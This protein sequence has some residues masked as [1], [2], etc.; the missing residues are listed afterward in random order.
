MCPD[1]PAGSSPPETG[2]E[3]SGE[4]EYVAAAAAEH[5]VDS[6][7]LA[8]GRF[9]VPT[10]AGTV[11]GLRYG[12][13]GQ[14][15]PLRT[16]LLHGG[17]Q[18]A[19]TW[20]VLAAALEQPALALDLPGHGRSHAR[21]DH[22]YSPRLLADAVVEAVMRACPDADTLVG[23]SLGGMAA[24]AAAPQVPRL[25]HL[26]LVDVSP[27]SVV[28]A[29]SAVRDVAALPPAPF[30]QLVADVAALTGRPVTDALLHGVWHNTRPV[31]EGRTWL[32]DR[33]ARVGSFADL[34]PDLEARAGQL[35]AVVSDR[36]SFVPP[37]DLL[38]LR[39]L[40]GARTIVLQGATH[41]VQGSRP[42][43]LAAILD[44]LRGA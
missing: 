1:Q 10:A 5:G 40:L 18:N 17:G 7:R 2:S 44:A 8:I 38:R 21:P 28:P 19:H 29:G 3:R 20:D 36:G 32:A 42:R 9:A 15:A 27:G 16:V 23:M 31:P 43:Q 39:A 22:E 33:D 6:S 37:A 26:V 25:R 34:W 35:T 4:T 14:P 24:L 41:S 30:P 13:A 11:S 12:R